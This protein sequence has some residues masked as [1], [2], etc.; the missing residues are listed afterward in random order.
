M[1][2]RIKQKFREHFSKP[3]IIRHWG[4]EHTVQPA[5]VSEQLGDGNKIIYFTP[6]NTRPWFYVVFVDSSWDFDSDK[7]RDTQ[8][9]MV[10]EVIEDEFGSNCYEG[11]ELCKAEGLGESCGRHHEDD[12]WFP[13]LSADSGCSWGTCVN[14]AKGDGVSKLQYLRRITQRPAEI[15]SQQ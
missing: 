5:V 15:G 14:L 11:Y 9:E 12:V 6:L 3:E 8:L 7:W 1:Y 2:E 13:V 4:Q 10:Y